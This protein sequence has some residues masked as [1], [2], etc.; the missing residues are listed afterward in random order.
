MNNLKKLRGT[1]MLAC[2]RIG[3]PLEGSSPTHNSVNVM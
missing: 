2:Y 3:D 1:K